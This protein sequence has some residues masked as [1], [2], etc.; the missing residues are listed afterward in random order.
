MQRQLYSIF[1]TIHVL[2][3]VGLVI[4]QKEDSHASNAT[5]Y[6]K[7]AQLSVGTFVLFVTLLFQTSFFMLRTEHAF[8]HVQVLHTLQEERTVLIVKVLVQLA[9]L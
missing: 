2:Q 1:L 9:L 5:Q 7:P 4:Q 6:V 8:K 3:A